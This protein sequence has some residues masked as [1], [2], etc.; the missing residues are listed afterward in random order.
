MKS[1]FKLFASAMKRSIKSRKLTRSSLIVMGSS[2][3]AGAA[4]YLS[5]SGEGGILGPLFATETDMVL[6]GDEAQ[7]R[8]KCSRLIKQFKVNDHKAV[9]S[10]CS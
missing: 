6:N 10:V 8:L 7:Q 2:A 1:V 5:A 3:L 9:V 4:Y